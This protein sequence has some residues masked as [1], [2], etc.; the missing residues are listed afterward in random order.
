MKGKRKG[1]NLYILGTIRLERGKTGKT[2]ITEATAIDAISNSKNER[3]KNGDKGSELSV[4]KKL[5]FE[6]IR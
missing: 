3:A 4:R 6:I 1:S 2:E 5:I